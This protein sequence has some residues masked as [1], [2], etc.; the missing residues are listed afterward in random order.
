MRG[1]ASLTEPLST[2]IRYPLGTLSSNREGTWPWRISG[3]RKKLCRASRKSTDK[4][5]P[6]NLQDHSNSVSLNKIL[7]DTG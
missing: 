3:T 6:L 1:L 2:G 4:A 5:C 7:N